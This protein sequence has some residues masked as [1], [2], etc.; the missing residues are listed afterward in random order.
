MADKVELDQGSIIVMEGILG[1]I[2]GT[3]YSPR[4]IYRLWYVNIIFDQFNNHLST[5]AI[6]MK[7]CCNV[8][9]LSACY[10]LQPQKIVT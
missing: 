6:A 3:E 10:L 9:V 4:M 7:M 1:L 8:P 5:T 2:G